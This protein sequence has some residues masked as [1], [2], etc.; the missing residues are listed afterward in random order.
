MDKTLRTRISES[1]YALRNPYAYLDGSGDFCA[2]V[3]PFKAFPV[4]TNSTYGSKH[5]SNR[6]IETKANELLK[7]LWQNRSELW[8][9][10]PPSDPMIVID[11]AKA[12]ELHGFGF[13]YEEDL[14]GFDGDSS[15]LRVAG[16]IDGN[17]RTVQISNRFSQSIRMFT[18]AH[19]LGHAVLHDVAGSLH[20]DRPVDGSFFSRDDIEYEADKFATYFL[21]PAKLV[22]ARFVEVFG[23]ETFSLN[24]GTAFALQCKSLYEV[25]ERC[26]SPRD[27][28]RLLASAGSYNGRF[29]RSLANQFRVS[30][31]AMAIRLEELSLVE[32]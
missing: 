15:Y 19:E 25:R 3:L 14:G 28:S 26:R 8:D 32:G 5:Y 22:R 24:E 4:P 18:A 7:I 17:A 13:F 11:P 6:E 30:I 12:L 16:L 2:E 21:M 27:L 10:H 23:T 1:R 9:G 29:F 31:E 20:R